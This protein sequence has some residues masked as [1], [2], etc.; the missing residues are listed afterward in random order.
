MEID[1][2][3]FV[4]QN[5]DFDIIVFNEDEY[6]SSKGNKLGK[7]SSNKSDKFKTLVN[8]TFPNLH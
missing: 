7:H 5:E 6:D 8:I 1:D 3:R 4:Y 2:L